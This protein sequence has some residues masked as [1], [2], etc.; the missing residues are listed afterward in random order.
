VRRSGGFVMRW[1]VIPGDCPE[2]AK[3]VGVVIKG[4]EINTHTYVFG[5]PVFK[6]QNGE[7]V[8]QVVGLLFLFEFKKNSSFCE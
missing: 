2:R 6:K 3:F 1:T 5:R 8:W 4:G 7:N